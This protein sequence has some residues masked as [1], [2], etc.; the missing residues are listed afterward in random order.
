[1]ADLYLAKT[2]IEKEEMAAALLQLQKTTQAAQDIYGAEAQ[3]TIG[4]LLRKQKKYEESTKALIEVRNKYVNY[5]TW[6]Y[7]AFLLIAD[8]Y[9]DLN[10]K[11]QAK[12]TLQS[13]IDN[14]ADEKVKE[15]ARQ[16][17]SLLN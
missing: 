17:L 7:E 13:I 1:M 3:Y 14:S 15:K 2:M 12:A 5:T 8:N 9:V 16:K 10:N 6:L 11:F 4:L